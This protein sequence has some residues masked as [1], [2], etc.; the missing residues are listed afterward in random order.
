LG[1]AGE[2]LA[3]KAL[4]GAGFQIV[5]RNWSGS[6]GEVDIVALDRAP[7][8]TSDGRQVEWLVLVEVRTRRGDRFGTALQSITPQKQAKLRQV[9]EEYVQTTKWPGP[10]RIDAVGVQMDGGGRLINIEH[11][12]GAVTG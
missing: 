12:R 8:Y 10:W 6:F 1:D 5:A 2:E 4:I 3:V 7:D 11:I 9:A